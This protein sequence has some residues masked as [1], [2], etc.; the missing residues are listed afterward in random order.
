MLRAC[1]IQGT[2]QVYV[3]A[4][5]YWGA[6]QT[7]LT[8]EGTLT[9]STLLSNPIATAITTPIAVFMWACGLALYFGLPKYYRQSP[10]RVPSFYTSLLRRKI[11]LVGQILLLIL[12]HKLTWMFSGSSL[13]LFYK[14]TGYQHHMDATGSICGQAPLF[15]LGVSLS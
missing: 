8:S 5:W 2:Q 15:Q 6:A 11:V 14:T 13:W 12:R 7:K 1:I 4:L 9:S 3:A 10:G